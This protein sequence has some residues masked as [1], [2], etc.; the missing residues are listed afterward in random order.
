MT[1]LLKNDIFDHLHYGH[2]SSKKRTNDY[3]FLIRKN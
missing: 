2:N 1:V 3:D